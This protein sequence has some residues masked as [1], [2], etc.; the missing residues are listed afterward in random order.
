MNLHKKLAGHSILLTACEFLLKPIFRPASRLFLYITRTKS[1]SKVYTQLLIISF[2]S[3][4]S[5]FKSHLQA[6]YKST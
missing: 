2:I 1:N 3:N 6:E 4:I 5:A